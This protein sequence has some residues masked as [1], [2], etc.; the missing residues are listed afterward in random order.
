MPDYRRIW[1][2]DGTY[3]FTISLPE[4]HANLLVPH[5]DDLPEAI[6]RYN[7]G[8]GQM[9]HV[10]IRNL[11]LLIVAGIAA[12]ASELERSAVRFS[13]YSKD[14]Q[15]TVLRIPEALTLTPSTG[16]S[17]TLKA[18]SAWQ[19]TGAIPQGDVYRP[20]GMVFSVEGANRYEAYLVI[21]N[22]RIVGFYLPG[23]EAFAPLPHPVLLPGRGGA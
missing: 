4:R 22:D 9:R 17:K 6:P 14:D 2:A 13:P 8:G 18:G 11:P 16:Y 12:C 19:R 1:V 7:V 15:H 21:S 23:E 20:V 10:L 3:S 5:I